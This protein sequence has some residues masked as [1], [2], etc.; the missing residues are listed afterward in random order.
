M[1]LGVVWRSGRSRSV[2]Q[3]W[4]VVWFHDLGPSAHKEG[5][6]SENLGGLQGI[7]ATEHSRWVGKN[8]LFAEAAADLQQELSAV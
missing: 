7:L 4:M 3:I 2:A 5:R 6:P 8:I 1:G